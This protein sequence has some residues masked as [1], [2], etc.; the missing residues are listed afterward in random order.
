MTAQ[1]PFG[2]LSV[3]N[4]R[5][6]PADGLDL[7]CTPPWATRALVACVL[8]PRMW[9]VPHD[10]V[11]EPA[12]GLGHMSAVLSEE[13]AAVLATDVFDYGTPTRTACA[14][15]STPRPWRRRRTSW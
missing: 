5:S 9:W 15:S 11:W 12:C 4:R 1:L 10:Q 3:M 14:T 13:Y 2:G 8:R 7:F 6:E